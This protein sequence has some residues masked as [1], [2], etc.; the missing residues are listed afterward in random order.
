MW[1][2]VDVLKGGDKAAD[3]YFSNV[4]EWANVD[5]TGV[6]AGAWAQM[7]RRGCV[8]HRIMVGA[9]KQLRE[10]NKNLQIEEDPDIEG[11]DRIRSQMLWDFA[12][13]LKNDQGAMIAPCKELREELVAPTYFKNTKE[14]ICVCSTDVIKDKIGRSPDRLMSMALRFAKRPK[15]TAGE[16]TQE[17]YTESSRNGKARAGLG[18]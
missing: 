13:W 18:M 14:Q 12:M 10:K 7:L 11:F 5:A 3:I 4:C 16:V 9:S 1:G 6:G 17:N 8:A 2:G 15:E